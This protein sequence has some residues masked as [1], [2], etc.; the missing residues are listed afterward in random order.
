MFLS[1]I[2]IV[3][4][5]VATYFVYKNANDYGRNAPLWAVITFFVGIGLQWV[6]P[7]IMVILLGII[8]LLTGSSQMQVESSLMFYAGFVGI[9]SLVL[10]AVAVLLILKFVSKMPEE[11][12]FVKPPSPPIEF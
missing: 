12:S 10:S 9:G 2:G 4:V 5:I 7:I 1:I 11:K 6:F 3:F 8:L